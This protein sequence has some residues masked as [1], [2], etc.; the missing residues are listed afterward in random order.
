M[1]RKICEIGCG[2]TGE[3]FIPQSTIKG[4]SLPCS[5][6][7][8]GNSGRPFQKVV[9]NSSLPFKIVKVNA[10][11]L[12]SG[13]NS[14]SPRRTE[15]T[16]CNLFASGTNLGTSP[17]DLRPCSP[18]CRVVSLRIMVILFLRMNTN[19]DGTRIATGSPILVSTK[20]RHRDTGPR[21]WAH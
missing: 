14:R 17:P 5:C 18:R 20:C 16:S 6:R 4:S 13:R 12:A 3:A 7:V 11:L 9:T 1:S 19:F 21:G 15:C 8:R 2:A 10:A